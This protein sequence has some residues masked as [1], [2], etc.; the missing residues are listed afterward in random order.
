MP[1]QDRRAGHDEVEDHPQEQDDPERGVHGPIVPHAA[2]AIRA[3]AAHVSSVMNNEILVRL[4][5]RLDRLP[6]LHP[7]LVVAVALIVAACKNGGG[8]S[9]Y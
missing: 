1:V 3:P 4:R 5:D 8:G 9:G 6:L 7:M 2:A